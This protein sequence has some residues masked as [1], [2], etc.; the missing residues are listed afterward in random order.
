MKSQELIEKKCLNFADCKELS[1]GMS[2][3]CDS[4]RF[5]KIKKTRRDYSLKWARKLRASK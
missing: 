1:Y 2:S 5:E 4:C 3:Y